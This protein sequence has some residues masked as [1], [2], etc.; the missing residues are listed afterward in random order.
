MVF[1]L[2]LEALKLANDQVFG[3]IFPNSRKLLWQCRKFARP[4][5]PN[6]HSL[7]TWLD[8]IES[9]GINLFGDL[10]LPLIKAITTARPSFRCRRRIG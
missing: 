5:K 3:I 4:V 7:A 8:P 2:E 10:F 6:A 1:T 9:K